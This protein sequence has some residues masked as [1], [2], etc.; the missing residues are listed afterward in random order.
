MNKDDETVAI[1]VLNKMR[2]IADND[3]E[4]IVD[5]NVLAIFE[6]LKPLEKAIILNLIMSIYKLNEDNTITI[7]YPIMCNSTLK[8]S[9]SHEHFLSSE[10]SSFKATVEPESKHSVEDLH[11]IEQMKLKHWMLKFGASGLI[12]Y[13]II[14]E[15]FGN[16]PENSS[17]GMTQLFNILE[18]IALK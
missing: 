11:T 18:K 7:C 10:E 15:I 1:P 9:N 13:N 8:A 17:S 4:G 12:L 14:I 5:G 6:K 16:N 3:H 2:R